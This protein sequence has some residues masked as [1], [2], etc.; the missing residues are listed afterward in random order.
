MGDRFWRRW[1][2]FLGITAVLSFAASLIWVRSASVHTEGCEFGD[3]LTQIPMSYALNRASVSLVQSILLFVLIS[4]L[5]TLIARVT[6]RQVWY[7]NSR[8]PFRF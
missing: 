4:W 3:V 6:R 8:I 7:N 2:Q 5:L 1:W